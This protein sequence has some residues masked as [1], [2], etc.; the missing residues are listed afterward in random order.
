MEFNAEEFDEY[1]ASEGNEDDV[2][3]IEV[4][5]S[6]KKETPQK[7]KGENSCRLSM[8]SPSVNLSNRANSVIFKPF[9]PG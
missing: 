4:E 5:A 9:R 6:V 7:N 2:I 1:V 8:N 3:N